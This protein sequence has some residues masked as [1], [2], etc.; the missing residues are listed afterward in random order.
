MKKLGPERTKPISGKWA[1]WAVSGF[2]RAGFLVGLT[3]GHNGGAE[4]VAEI[5][6][7]FVEL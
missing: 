4:T 7:Q 2:A 1:G 5:V 6:G 3:L